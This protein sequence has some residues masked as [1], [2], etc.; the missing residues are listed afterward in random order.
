MRRALIVLTT[1]LFVAAGVVALMPVWTHPGHEEPPPGT[2]GPSCSPGYYKNHVGTWS[3]L[4]CLGDTV[5]NLLADLNARGPGGSA[6]R[7]AAVN[8]IQSCWAQTCEN[9]LPCNNDNQG[10]IDNKDGG[11]GKGGEKPPKDP[12]K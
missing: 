3:G 11:C 2:C 10:C 5:E 8:A 1:A 4:G 12:T 9:P 6:R 7:T